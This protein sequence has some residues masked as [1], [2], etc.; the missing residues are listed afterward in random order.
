MSTDQLFIEE[1]EREV[2]DLL[3]LGKNNPEIAHALQLSCVAIEK[4][5][6]AVYRKLEVK[7]RV[8]AALR[9]YEIQRNEATMNQLE[10]R[11]VG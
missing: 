5:L 1:H 11:V 2:L 8:Q 7:N 6:T 9:W 4:R 3:V 10:T